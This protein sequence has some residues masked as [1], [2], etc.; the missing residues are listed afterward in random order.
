MDDRL[1][2]PPEALTDVHIAMCAATQSSSES[3]APPT[4]VRLGNW[5]KLAA[6]ICSTN[7]T[8]LSM[9]LRKCCEGLCRDYGA[10]DVKDG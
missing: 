3:K 4:S 8:S 1:T 6:E 5:G 9:F 7:G 2:L 10:E